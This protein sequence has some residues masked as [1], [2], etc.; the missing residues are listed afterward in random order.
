M[1][2]KLLRFR[3]TTRKTTNRIAQLVDTI[4]DLENLKTVTVVAGSY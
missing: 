2:T 1:Q 4:T 3:S